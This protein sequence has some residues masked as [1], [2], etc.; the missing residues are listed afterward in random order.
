MRTFGRIIYYTFAALIF[1]LFSCSKKIAPVKNV[2]TVDTTLLPKTD[3]STIVKKDT[4]KKQPELSPFEKKLIAYGLVDVTT[5]DSTI[6]VDIRYSTI[7]NVM[8]RDL[9]GDFDKAYLQK[10]VAEKLVKAQKIL[11][12]TFPQYSLIIYDAARPLIV[13]QWM[14]DSVDVPDNVRYKYLSDPQYGSLHNFGAAVDLSIYDDSAGKPL[15]MG[16]PFDC[17]CRLAYPYFE[18]RFLR[19]KKLS[20]QAY[21]NRLLLRN[22]MKKAGFSGITTEWWHFNSC[23]RKTAKK[24]YPVI[25]DFSGLETA[26]AS[27][28]QPEIDTEKHNIVFRVQIKISKR[29][30]NKHCPCFKGLK[31]WQYYHKGYYKYTAGEFKNLSD[32]I[33][34]RNKLRKMGFKDCFV[35]AFDGN[36]RISFKDAYKIM[37]E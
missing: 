11:K 7:N 24:K 8:H 21:R 29:K 25:K 35:A 19:N 23:S 14:W 13:Q 15:D 22:I 37:E 6:K 18:K 31:V 28:E 30:L 34:Y 32:A 4:V 16:T 26:T 33:K 17:F 12:D 5:L 2:A 20:L 10:D 27:K 9:Y 3:S 1:L 36:K